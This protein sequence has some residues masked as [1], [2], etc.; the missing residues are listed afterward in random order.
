V[1]KVSFIKSIYAVAIAFALGASAATSAPHAHAAILGD[2][3]VR[4][5][6]G[7]PLK[8]RIPISST[9]DE[10]ISTSCF[11][12]TYQSQPAS[13]ERD[14]R[15]SLQDGSGVKMLML[16]TWAPFNEPFAL[17]VLRNRCAGQGSV[18]R[19]YTVLLDPRP[20]IVPPT[21]TTQTAT[22]TKLPSSAAPTT[23]DTRLAGTSQA[24]SSDTLD[25]IA[26]GVFPKSIKR[27]ARY[28]AALRQL[29]PDLGSVGNKTPLPPG[30]PLI[31][32]DLKLLSSTREV[33]PAVP[34]TVLP[35][36]ATAPNSSPPNAAVTAPSSAPDRL[37]LGPTRR[38]RS[39]D[40]SAATTPARAPVS[41]PAS[42]AAKAQSG[43]RFELRLSAG[44]IDMTRSATIT[45]Q[46]RALLRE[47]QL[48]LDSDDQLAQFLSL[49]NTVKQMEN[50]L[51][52]M[53]LRM[54]GTLATNPG[55]DPNAANSTNATSNATP[56]KPAPAAAPP[57][58]TSANP[59]E[60][61]TPSWFTRVPF[62]WIIVAVVVLAA[63][64]AVVF[65][66][67]TWLSRKR[68]DA[69]SI[70]VDDRNTL[71]EKAMA[72]TR[73]SDR[74]ATDDAL[75]DTATDRALDSA[76]DSSLRTPAQSSAN[77]VSPADEAQIRAEEAAIKASAARR[78]SA[79]EA[80]ALARKPWLKTQSAGGQSGT[81]AAA[82]GASPM[83]DAVKTVQMKKPVFFDMLADEGSQVINL[84]DTPASSVDFPLDDL[85]APTQTTT[86][87]ASDEQRELRAMYMRERYPELQTN[88]VSLDDPSSLVNAAR[89]YFEE[90]ETESLHVSGREKACDLLT[91]ALEERPQ[92]MRYWLALLEIY[93][94]DGMAREYGEL[95]AKFNFL[96]AQS[97]AW[98]LVA[99]IG[100]EIDPSNA[101]F[102]STKP[103]EAVDPVMLNWLNA[104][105]DDVVGALAAE[106]RLAVLTD[107]NLTDEVLA[108][109]RASYS[110]KAAI[111]TVQ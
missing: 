64:L 10:D 81:D 45:E 13:L 34:G 32:P 73:N 97:N 35:S 26:E 68:R 54:G 23:N 86:E 2:A 98:P 31:L 41:A 75:R 95:A 8:I 55:A 78:R 5:Y 109:A 63:A 72:T 9:P 16:Q 87:I 47:R 22:A 27:K 84:N 56:A 102:A 36:S 60:T 90:D 38:E 77:N 52:E 51:N 67:L 111:E 93:R 39:E 80:E 57:K 33:R 29:N 50:R 1:L 76:A 94:A 85:P 49:K 88:T 11:S 61:T 79:D 101:L 28:I 104:P 43:E 65:A 17:V 70:A 42:A 103:H 110:T 62:G 92:Q 105:A 18:S 44:A 100:H 99:A 3:E 12:V 59:E 24:G 107:F 106:F 89:N 83:A 15:P 14:L 25:A 19:E 82:V 30:K 46:E 91:Y 66:I 108:D 6:L 58:Q 4:S 40:S 53:Q 48:L 71:L 20:E 37:T 69:R 7:E 21:P 74:A 96:F